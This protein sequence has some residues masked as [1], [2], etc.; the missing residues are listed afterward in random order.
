MVKR[1]SF[2]N[3]RMHWLFIAIGAIV[4]TLIGISLGA[5]KN[6]RRSISVVTAH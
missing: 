2:L 6:Q 1:L 3:R 4:A 5:L